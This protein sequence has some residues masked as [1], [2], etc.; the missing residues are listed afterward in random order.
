M[1]YRHQDTMPVVKRGFTWAYYTSDTSDTKTR[2]AHGSHHAIAEVS[3]PTEPTEPSRVCPLH[4]EEGLDRKAV[5]HW[6][7]PYEMTNPP[8]IRTTTPQDLLVHVPIELKASRDTCELG[9]IGAYSTAFRPPGSSYQVGL[10]SRQSQ[11]SLFLLSPTVNSY[12]F[13]ERLKQ[14]T[15]Q[16]SAVRCSEESIVI[17]ID[18]DSLGNSASQQ[19]VGVV[20]ILRGP[21]PQT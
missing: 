12:V 6:T 7:L 17:N 2:A 13:P 4:D 14:A 10:G 16:H 15:P 20:E 21:R 1:H 8:T 3:E 19:R 11:L 18:E 5:A 9:Q